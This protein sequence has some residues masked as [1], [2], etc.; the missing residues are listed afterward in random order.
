MEKADLKE[1]DKYYVLTKEQLL[2]LLH[3]EATLQALNAGG[4]DNWTWYEEALENKEDPQGRLVHYPTLRDKL[5]WR[6]K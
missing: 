2:D 3:S 5:Q 6:P 4:V 1:V